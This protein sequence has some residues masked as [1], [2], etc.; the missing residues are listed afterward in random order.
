MP[1][2]KIKEFE[3]KKEKISFFLQLSKEDLYHVVEQWESDRGSFKNLYDK[4][5]IKLL[6][7]ATPDERAMFE[8]EAREILQN[9]TREE[10]IDVILKERYH[11]AKE[12]KIR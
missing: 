12:G 11:E 1:L 7:S 2:S 9:Y 6:G 8:E 5:L 3:N 4:E 10:L